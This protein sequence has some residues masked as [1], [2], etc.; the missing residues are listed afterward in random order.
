MAL[1]LELSASFDYFNNLCRTSQT[2][3]ANVVLVDLFRSRK[4]ADVAD[5]FN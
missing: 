2:C 1:R 3:G 4:T 5:Q